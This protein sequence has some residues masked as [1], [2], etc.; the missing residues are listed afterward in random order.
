MTTQSEQLTAF[1]S[2]PVIDVSGLRSTDPLQQQRVAQEIGTAA[3]QVGFFQIVGHGISVHQQ[4]QLVAA[5]KAFFALEEAEKMQYYIGLSN[6]HRGYVPQGEEAPDPNAVDLK[7]AFDIAMELPADDPDVGPDKPL[8][9]PN[10]WPRLPGFRTSVETYYDAAFQLG[11]DL[12][13]GFALALNLPANRFIQYINKPPS[14]L[15]LI[16]YPFNPE[17]VDTQGIGAH[18]DYECFTILKPTTGG[19][20]VMNGGGKWVAVPFREDALIINIGDMLEIWTNGAFVATSHRVRKVPEERYAFPLFFACDYEVTVA[21][22]PELVKPGEALRYQPLK[23][24]DHLLAQTMQTFQYL[25][26]RLASGEMKMPE[27]AL[28]VGSLGQHGRH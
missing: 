11:C 28:T 20:E 6:N 3:R 17:A 10:P 27:Q 5:A 26:R 24:G 18:T 14:Q 9:G 16:H 15:R 22:L 19:L 1:E 8:L 13:R 2:I 12:M 4:A 23:A 25:K 21:P 7:E